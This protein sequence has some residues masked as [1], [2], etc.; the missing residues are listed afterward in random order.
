MNE[1][2]I[3]RSIRKFENK[4]V[5][6]DKVEKLLRAAMQ[7]PSAHNQQP[8]EFLVIND[9]ELLDKMSTAGPYASMLNTAT[10][11][12]ITLVNNSNMRCPEYYLQDMS[13][14]TENIL[15]EVVALGLGAV[16]IGVTPDK[17]RIDFVN[18]IFDF[19][20]HIVP[21]SIVAIGYPDESQEN[22]FIDR[23]NSDKVNYNKY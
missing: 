2:F 19:P 6:Q 22:K 23:Y 7:S 16:W 4:Q 20:N 17:P 3:R 14:T 10:L 21:F 13:A 11:A 5:E 15:L 9:R 8:W 1:I 12:I 18:E